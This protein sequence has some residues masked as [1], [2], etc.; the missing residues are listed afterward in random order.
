MR[1]D[2][3]SVCF[4]SIAALA[5][6][7]ASPARAAQIGSI[8]VCYACQ[9]T[10]DPVI[11]AALTAHPDVAYDGLLFAFKN[12]SAFPI[13]GAVI[14]VGGTASPADSFALPTIP[15]GGELIF[16]P[17]LD[18]DVAKHPS[19]GLFE[20]TGS[21]M[22]TSEGDG[23]VDDKSIFKFT[24]T[25]NGVAVTST[26]AGTSTAIPG[27]FTPAD[28]GLFLPWRD[29]GS[30]GR[31]SFLGNGPDGDGGCNNC[32]YGLVATLNAGAASTG[33]FLQFTTSTLPSGAVGVP[34]TANIG[35][36]G[37]TSPYTFSTTALPAGLVLSAGGT[38][39]GTPAAPGGYAFT[40]KVTDSGGSSLTGTFVVTFAPL[41]ITV[42][43]PSPLPPGM[44]GVE[45]PAQLLTAIGGAGTYAWSVTGGN[46]P[47]GL[48]LTPDGTLS[49]I[50]SVQGSF[51]ITVSATDGSVTASA[52]LGLTIRPQ[53]PDLLLSAGSL[54]FSL[55]APSV[56][57]PASR[58]VAV[59]STQA[60]QQ[61]AF[62]VAVSPAA[63]WLAV[64]NGTQTPDAISVSLTNAA[65]ALAAGTYQT[66][67][68]VTCTTTV[69][70]GRGQ[71]VAV[72][73]QVVNAAPLLQVLS[74][75]LN[76]G[77]TAASLAPISQILNI[78]NAGGGSLT[79]RSISCEASWC[80]V[81]NIPASVSGGA[82]AAI[83]ITVNP[84]ATGPGFFRTQVD[85]QTS[86]GTASVPV[87]LFVAASSGLSL[88]P[89]GSQ[90]LMPQ[91]GAPGNSKG[92]FLVTT[93]SSTAIA[94]TASVLPGA[95]W[96]L[97]GV[98]SGTSTS[99]QSSAATFSID[100]AAVR[101]FA[102]GAYYGRIEITAPGASNS[103]QDFVVVLN[104][105]P[106]TT[107]VR[108]D[109]QPAGLL[110]LANT[111]VNPPSQ[112][113][114]IYSG[115]SAAVSFQD[116]ATSSPSWLS[117]SPG[118]GTAVLGAPG[119]TTVSAN[120]AGLKPGV[121]RGNVNYAYA[122]AAVR[123]VNVTLIVAA[124]AGNAVPTGTPTTL[125][126]ASPLSSVTQAAG[127]TPSTLVPAQTG[128]VNNFSAPAAWPTPLA[129]LLYDDC[130]SLVTNGQIVATFT[131]GDA[132]LI[133][134]L[135]NPSQAL[136]SGTWT[137]RKSA[138]QIT[139]N[140]QASAPGLSPASLQLTG[141]V[142]PNAAPVLTPHGSLNGFYPLVGS[143]LA[144]GTI[145]QIYGQNLA[146]QITQPGTLPL[147]TVA[148]GTS[149]IIGGLPA[150]LFY[151][152]PNQVN[153]QIPF[154][155]QANQQYQIIA[156]ANGA[157]TTP[158]TI[159]LSAAT[160]GIAVF[161]GTILAQHSDGS[162]VS[163]TAPAKS[164]EYLVAYLL[165]LGLVDQPVTDGGPA[166]SSTLAQPLIPPV[167]TINGAPYP[168]LFAGLTPGL[169]GLY[170][171][172]FQVP[173]GLPAGNLTLVITQG[174]NPSNQV[175][176]PYQP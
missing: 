152:S 168:L 21:T 126:L 24:G 64:T 41:P 78:A 98:T 2:S 102:P 34:Y 161:N 143:S 82:S 71:N 65:L 165:G 95:T 156:Q 5:S 37:G 128:L 10:G 44:S 132:P 134:S 83:P 94:W 91:G 74:D 93:T 88:A 29:V 150:P 63:S 77:T 114:T 52:T 58:I 146:S 122:G 73:L 97:A 56:I 47:A 9:N 36:A 18:S 31:T 76:F 4:F 155:L 141:V 49:G 111:G 14:S 20:H 70:A 84:A 169:V 67:I 11:D 148:N 96:L 57:L 33:S 53:A 108:P 86:G 176:L 167:F 160:P 170:Q 43:T 72:T 3:K 101:T 50:P 131:N 124:G 8:T 158:D 171:M 17:G 136:Y 115:S 103:P 35:V 138:A 15:A 130:G 162:L 110:F 85:I 12:T 135:A 129:I 1:L 144:P 40:V 90:F 104:V 99:T 119:V 113:V 42:T 159:Q 172:N 154:E 100:P 125:S 69:C 116:S 38:L 164:G 118:V 175:T 59:E 54:G 81:G 45:Y 107:P 147:P 89:S 66:T 25:S 7:A 92:S 46:L 145:V 117:V 166:P 157:I 106:A 163:Q 87:T 19:G 112:T 23:G 153:A 151:V 68:S 39:S 13:T 105:S 32:Y 121:Y 123:T 142:T 173:A 139:I 120:V 27:T 6:L 55:N 51:P 133:L 79:I 26:T 61:V 16:L 109:P 75:L 48:A 28:P 149:V 60:A 80:S 174:A 137:P 140:A 30:T 62:S 127:C 22:D